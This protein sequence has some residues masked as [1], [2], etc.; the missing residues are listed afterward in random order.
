M[1]IQVSNE[2]KGI[3]L[4]TIAEHTKYKGYVAEEKYDTWFLLMW[5]M[6]KAGRGNK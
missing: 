1:K 6:L 4:A 5:T 3:F 2:V